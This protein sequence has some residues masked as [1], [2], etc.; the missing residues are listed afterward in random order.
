MG[1]KWQK[2]KRIK[3]RVLEK[4]TDWLS[5]VIVF[6]NN[7]DISTENEN[8][9]AVLGRG[10]RA[11]RTPVNGRKEE[12]MQITNK[13]WQTDK[14]SIESRKKTIQK[15]SVNNWD[16]DWQPKQGYGST[17]DGNTARRFFRNSDVSASITGLDEGII[18]RFHVILQPFGI[19]N[20]C[21]PVSVTPD[22]HNTQEVDTQQNV[23]VSECHSP[24]SDED[25][26]PLV[27]VTP[28][29][30]NTHEVDT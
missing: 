15:V 9:A 1:D 10:R 3:A 26:R 8:A 7:E 18:K 23:D 19:W 17:N 29:A 5:T 14:Q 16:F 21:A 22:A 11:S 4:N 13:K 30:H 25:G 27:S 20:H 24:T 2:A 6:G 12:K 28:D